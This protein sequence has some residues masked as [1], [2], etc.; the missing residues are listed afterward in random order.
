[1][2]C[3]SV[4]STSSRCATR[5]GASVGLINIAIQGETRAANCTNTTPSD[6]QEA[7]AAAVLLVQVQVMAGH[8]LPFSAKPALQLAQ[9]QTPSYVP[10]TPVATMPLVQVQVEA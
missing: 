9:I 3:P 2:H 10:E 5:A 1:M 4:G 6:V 8:G 7:P